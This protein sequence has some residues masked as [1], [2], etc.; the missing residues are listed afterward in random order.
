[1]SEPNELVCSSV[2]ICIPG[3]TGGK[4]QP[5]KSRNA[6]EIQQTLPETCKGKGTNFYHHL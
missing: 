1:M 6:I 2:P 5:N 3:L 4:A